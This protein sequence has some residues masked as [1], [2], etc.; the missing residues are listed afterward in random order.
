MTLSQVAGAH[1]PY[2][3]ERWSPG[4]PGRDPVGV[5]GL[6][7][8][9]VAYA[10]RRHRGAREGDVYFL[11]TRRGRLVGYCRDIEEV[12]EFVDLRALRGPAPGV[13]DTA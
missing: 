5:V 2:G 1:W 6:A 11:V 13:E 10:R 4:G 7:A 9:D 3:D 8:E 12:A